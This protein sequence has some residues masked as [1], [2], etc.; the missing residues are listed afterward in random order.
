MTGFFAALA[1]AAGNGGG[2]SFT[3]VVTPAS[4]ASIGTISET[5]TATPSGGSS[6][7]TYSWS[8]KSGTGI[9]ITAPTSA[10]TTFYTLGNKAVSGVAVC[11]VQDNSG[12]IVT[13]N[14][15]QISLL[16]EGEG[17]E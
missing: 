15:V 2:G 1:G 13:S 8:L 6:P 12:A 11:T 14:D 3:V 17:H 7:Y 9:F 16:A 4:A 5:V 10:A